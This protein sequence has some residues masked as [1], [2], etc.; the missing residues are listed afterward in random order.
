MQTNSAYGQLLSGVTDRQLTLMVVTI[1]N[2]ITKNGDKLDDETL[3][4][5]KKKFI[6]FQLNE[7]TFRK[8][9]K[10]FVLFEPKNTTFNRSLLDENDDMDDEYAR[11]NSPLHL[12]GK[13]KPNEKLTKDLM[14]SA[15][16]QSSK[17]PQHQVNKPSSKLSKSVED[18][19]NDKCVDTNELL[20]KI[21]SSG[22]NFDSNYMNNQYRSNKQQ[23]LARTMAD[24]NREELKGI[25]RRNKRFE[26]YHYEDLNILPGQ[27]WSIPQK[28]PPV[29][30]GGNSKYSPSI[31]QTALIGTLLGDAK[32]TEMGSIIQDKQ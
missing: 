16:N 30:V 25:C 23:Q 4:F 5:L 8:F 12:L 18:Y 13:K 31:D 27:E 7:P 21:K 22:C 20:K 15:F 19:D 1:Y 3:Q 10:E 17:D 2:D 24:R 14:S 6:E 32:N 9:V 26:A 28:H 29:C 11:F